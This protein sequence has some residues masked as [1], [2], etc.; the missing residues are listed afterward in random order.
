LR[1]GTKK[2]GTCLGYQLL[3]AIELISEELAEVAIEA[4][5]VTG[6]VDQL[7][8]ERGVVVSSVYKPKAGG[9]MNGI[10][11]W[12]IISSALCLDLRSDRGPSCPIVDNGFAGCVRFDF[13]SV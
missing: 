4:A 1:D 5:G 10:G 7:V 13:A 9:K 11:G 2:R 12:T 6:A 8:K 3:F